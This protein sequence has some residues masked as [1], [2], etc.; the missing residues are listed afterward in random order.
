MNTYAIR[1]PDGELEDLLAAVPDPP[2]G[3]DHDDFIPSL[4]GFMS[5]EAEPFGQM[6]AQ[7]QDHGDQ[8]PS[9]EHEGGGDFDAAEADHGAQV[10]GDQPDEEEKRH[11]EP[12]GPAHAP[13]TPSPSHSHDLVQMLIGIEMRVRAHSVPK[14]LLLLDEMALLGDEPDWH[15]AA[16]E[17]L[18]QILDLM[19][20]QQAKS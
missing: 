20:G 15:V 4:E 7:G 6:D 11:A 14:A 16:G 5:R 17:R 12:S 13:A 8:Q 10:P 18:V 9:P 2:A 3:S 1:R 19:P